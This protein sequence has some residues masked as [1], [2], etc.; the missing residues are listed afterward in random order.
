MPKFTTFLGLS[1]PTLSNIAILSG[2]AMTSQLFAIGFIIS[3]ELFPTPVRNIS[4][5][6]QQIFTRIGTILSPHFF[7]YT[8]FW[9][10]APYLFMSIIMLINLVLFFI[11]IPETKNHP[12]IDHMPHKSERIFATKLARENLLKSDVGSSNIKLDV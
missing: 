12:M 5:S 9:A 3:G 4:A 8:S 7:F 1:F 11:V 6:F 10:P 2:T